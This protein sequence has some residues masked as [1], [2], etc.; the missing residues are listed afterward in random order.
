MVKLPK[1]VQTR[2]KTAVYRKADEFEYMARTRTENGVFMENLVNDPEMG[3]VLAEYMPGNS[4]KTYIKDAVLNRY[5]KDKTKKEHG[6]GAD[7]I[8]AVLGKDSSQI[9]TKGDVSLHRVST[10]EFLVLSKGTWIKWESA[11]RKAL[12]FIGGAPGFAKPESKP[13][14]LLNLSTQGRRLTEGDRKHL[15]RTLGKI[16]VMVRLGSSS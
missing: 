7:A 8:R 4:V 13:L 6:K 3:G 9:E 11:L 2:I 14:I 15:V 12:E 16:S 1:D 5:A 10:G